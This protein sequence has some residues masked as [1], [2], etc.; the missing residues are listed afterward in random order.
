MQV[1]LNQKIDCDGFIG[2]VDGIESQ[3]DPETLQET[4]KAVSVR[5]GNGARMRIKM[6]DLISYNA[7]DKER[8]NG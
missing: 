5:F 6:E 8:E 1:H 2:H 4:Q 7:T 3:L